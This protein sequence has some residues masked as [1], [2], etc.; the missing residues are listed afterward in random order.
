MPTLGRNHQQLSPE[1]GRIKQQRTMKIVNEVLGKVVR[2][3][4]K[5][6]CPKIDCKSLKV[7]FSY[8]EIFL[9]TIGLFFVLATI[10]DPEAGR[11][12]SFIGGIAACDILAMFADKL[13]K[14]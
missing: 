14:K 2:I 11:W 8:A 9:G 12:T 10:L 4:S 1:S 7:P 3:F 13:R 5:K 6:N